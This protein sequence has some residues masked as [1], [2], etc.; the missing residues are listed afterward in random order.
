MPR[1]Q[2]TNPNLPPPQGYS[3]AVAA[4]G[5][6]I[7]F[8]SM[9][10]P[11][12]A[13]GAVVGRDATEQA[14]RVLTNLREILELHGSGFDD[15]VKVSAYITRVEDIAG[16]MRTI[17]EAFADPPPAIALAVVVALPNPAFLVEI[18][19]VAVLG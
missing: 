8:T 17:G 6:E 15:V 7:F 16:V 3:R 13:A 14:A 18:D 11:V 10:A 12:D 4:T 5:R 19:A 1:R 2:L 9:T